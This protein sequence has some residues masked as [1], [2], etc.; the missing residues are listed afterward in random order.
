MAIIIGD[1]QWQDESGANTA[2][3]WNSAGSVW[4]NTTG[5][6]FTFANQAWITEISGNHTWV[7][8]GG[9]GADTVD[10][11]G[12]TSAWNGSF[13][14]DQLYQSGSRTTN[15][16]AILGSAYNDTFLWKG[17]AGAQISALDGGGGTDTLTDASS[18]TAFSITLSSVNFQNI[19]YLQ[20]TSL[21]DKLGRVFPGRNGG[22]AEPERIPSGVRT[23]LTSCGA[24][25]EQIPTGLLRRTGWIPSWMTATTT[26][27]M[28]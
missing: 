12:A 26:P 19:E 4:G 9:G 5:D 24:A 21:A 6:S 20:G 10:F 27:R 14:L 1:S 8:N 15:T 23:A 17:G 11:S 7:L 25:P 3:G 16:F 28:R 13:S 2:G 22:R 18:T